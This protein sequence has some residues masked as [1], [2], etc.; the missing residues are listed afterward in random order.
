MVSDTNFHYSE[1]GYEEMARHL[2]FSAYNCISTTAGNLSGISFPLRMTKYG[3][4]NLH[5]IARVMTDQR[6]PDMEVLSRWRACG[7]GKPSSHG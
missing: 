3:A 2:V 1:C 5:T 6:R 7:G 4:T